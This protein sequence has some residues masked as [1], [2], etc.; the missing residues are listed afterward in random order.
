[1]SEVG[2]HTGYPRATLHLACSLPLV[3][4]VNDRTAGTWEHRRA[5]RPPQGAPP[6]VEPSPSL[7]PGA[8]DPQ[9]HGRS[10]LG[11][12]VDGEEGVAAQAERSPSLKQGLRFSPSTKQIGGK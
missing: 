1:M 10:I 4:D 6:P 5:S 3:T 9:T 11:G 7:C 8:Q 2:V 12:G